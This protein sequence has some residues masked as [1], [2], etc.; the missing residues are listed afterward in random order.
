MLSFFTLEQLFMSDKLYNVLILCTGNVAVQGSEDDQRRAFQN[1]FNYIMDRVRLFSVPPL[2]K[3]DQLT[4]K[5][6]M[7]SIGQIKDA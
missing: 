3:L 2:T 7:D 5:R 6:E 1:V 4:I